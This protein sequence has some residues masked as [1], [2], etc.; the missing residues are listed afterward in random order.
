[1]VK[2]NPGKL[3]WVRILALFGLI[4]TPLLFASVS[5]ASAAIVAPTAARVT[6]TSTDSIGIAWTNGVA[7]LSENFAVEQS[8]DNS[9]YTIVSSTIATSTTSY[10]ATGLSYN[11]RYWFRVTATAAGNLS[12]S[13]AATTSPAYTLAA[14]PGTP[15]I[16]TPTV[17]TLP[18]TIVD[19]NNPSVSTT[20]AIYNYTTNEFLGYSDGAATTTA[21]AFYQST[22]T[23]GTSFAATGLTANT[24]YQ[25]VVI[26]RN[27]D[28]SSTA[29]STASTATYTLANTP[30]SVSATA[31]NQS[32]ITVSW[33]GDSTSYYVDNTT[34]STYY[35]WTTGGSYAF[36]SLNC[37]TTYNF[38]VKGRNGTGTE[39]AKGSASAT[40]NACSGGGYIPPSPPAASYSNS[41]AAVSGTVSGSSVV[42]NLSA[43]EAVS[44]AI[45]EN[46]TFVGASW[47]PYSSIK[48]FNLS[49]GAGEKTIYVKF[50][51]A[52]SAESS[53]KSITVK[54]TSAGSSAAPAT[55]IPA[56]T[57]A[58]QVSFI[59]PASLTV[60]AG[61]TIKYSYA[62][63]N[64]TGKTKSIKVTRDLIK[65]GKIVTRATGNY[66]IK[67]GKS[68]NF[69][70]KQ[71]FNKKLAP[72]TYTVMI[73][74]YDRSKGV[75]L[76]NNSFDLV[77]Q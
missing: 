70:V 22:S 75:N 66:S 27:G 72:G 28:A 12:T 42:L 33:S 8:L 65:D 41:V 59:L 57:T 37:G 35:G 69:N 50:R 60:S 38:T 3:P 2:T 14:T 24:A 51:Y 5:Y 45:S 26:A 46:S 74:I 49:S 44:M 63:A 31:N 61:Q 73:R 77:I 15:T 13:S 25:F 17:S 36:T 11:T 58:T 7:D 6:S 39:T 29:T 9:T 20:Y 21:A 64:N 62:W 19:A 16:G 30:S 47:E 48:T 56:P 54:T 4:L 55:Y 76:D 23:W 40:T 34:A 43:P 52:N 67:N 32:Q 71:T 10:T 68:F 18:I 53:V 1:M